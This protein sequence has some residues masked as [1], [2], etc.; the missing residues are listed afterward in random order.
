MCRRRSQPW[1]ET[2]RRAEAAF[3]FA[4]RT[5]AR[6]HRHRL[7]N[8]AVTWRARRGVHRGATDV[9]DVALEVAATNAARHGVAARV[10]FRADLAGRR[11]DETFDRSRPTRPT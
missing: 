9:S 5:G 7:R 4:L 1:A 8:I 3:C 2:E 11:R 6:T 10:T